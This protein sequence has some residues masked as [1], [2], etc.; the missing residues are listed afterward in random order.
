MLVAADEGATFRAIHAGRVVFADWL[1]GFG[2]MTIV[3]HGSGYMTLYGQADALARKAGD[4]VR[5]ATCSVARAA[6]AARRSAGLYFEVRQNGR[7]QD[8]AAWLARR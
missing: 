4:R 3:D 8:P 1:R 5:P 2:L 6:A 7:A